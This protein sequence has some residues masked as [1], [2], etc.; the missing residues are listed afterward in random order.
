MDGCRS[1]RIR[2]SCEYIEAPMAHSRY[3]KTRTI[4]T[5]TKKVVYATIPI[6]WNEAQQKLTIGER[7]GSFRGCW[8]IG[9]FR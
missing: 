1:R 7:K 4:P 2:L 8:R 3:T 6:E 9:R 5:T